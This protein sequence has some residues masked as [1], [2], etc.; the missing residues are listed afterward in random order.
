MPM[1]KSSRMTPTS[2]RLSTWCTSDTRPSALGPSRTPATM[3]PGRAGSLIRWNSRMTSRETAKMIA[4][5]LRTWYSLM[6]ARGM[7]LPRARLG[8]AVMQGTNLV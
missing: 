7:S 2:A 8:F 3:N 6:A 5:S 1:V 4:R